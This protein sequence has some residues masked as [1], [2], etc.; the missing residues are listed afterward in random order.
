MIQTNGNHGA[1]HTQT[2]GAKRP[3]EIAAAIHHFSR[4][5]FFWHTQHHQQQ[6]RLLTELTIRPHGY[7]STLDFAHRIRRF[8]LD[9]D[10]QT[11][12]IGKQKAE[13]DLV[14]IEFVRRPIF[15]VGGNDNVR[16]TAGARMTPPSFRPASC[17]SIRPWRPWRCPGFP[18]RRLSCFCHRP[19]LVLARLATL[20]RGSPRALLL[21]DRLH[22]R[23]YSLVDR[24]RQP[25]LQHYLLRRCC[26]LLLEQQRQSFFLFFF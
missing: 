5:I 15:A 24:P 11:V 12:A 13:R 9:R 3:T 18:S 19:P 14:G 17:R 2:L 4:T 26:W 6:Q 1:T 23:H 21:G 22:H 20:L 25:Q 10:R 16:V 7:Q 8:A